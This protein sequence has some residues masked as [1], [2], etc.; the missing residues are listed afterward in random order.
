MPVAVG[1]SSAIRLFDAAQ[2]LAPEMVELNSGLHVPKAILS[3]I[4]RASFGNELLHI[5]A[6]NAM[7][8]RRFYSE[9]FAIKIQVESPCSPIS[10]TIIKS[11]LFGQITMRLGGVTIPEPIL[12]RNWHVQQRRSHVYK[13]HVKTTP[14]EGDN[15]F[16]VS[17]D[18]PKGGEQFGLINA[19]DEL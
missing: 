19:G 10:A 16:I 18:V 15:S 1:E 6:G 13:G 7:A 12:A 3:D 5:I 8:F 14:I 4:P 2:P 9:G 17:G 11:E